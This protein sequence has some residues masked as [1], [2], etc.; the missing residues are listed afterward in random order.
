MKRADL[1][2]AAPGHYVIDERE[3]EVVE[4]YH[5]NDAADYARGRAALLTAEHG[6]RF[7]V[8]QVID[9]PEIGGGE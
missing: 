5:H 8:T 6:R 2:Y 7:Y 1:A 3:D 4:T 9:L